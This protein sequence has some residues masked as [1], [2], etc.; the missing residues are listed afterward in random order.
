MDRWCPA[1]AK[2]QG[3]HGRQAKPM[4]WASQAAGLPQGQAGGHGAI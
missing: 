3:S 1:E 4:A 2:R